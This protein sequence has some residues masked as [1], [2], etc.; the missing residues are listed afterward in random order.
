MHNSANYTTDSLNWAMHK[1]VGVVLLCFF[2]SSVRAQENKQQ[3]EEIIIEGKSKRLTQ[4][5]HFKIADIQRIQPQD[6]GQVLQ[7]AAG[8]TMRSYGGLGG[9]KTFSIRGLGGEHTKLVVNGLPYSNAQ[10]S[11]V[12]FSLF[13]PDNVCELSLEH[14]GKINDLRPAS[15]QVMGSSI[16]I[17]TFENSFADSAKTQVRKSFTLGSFGQ[18]ENYGAAK[19]NGNNSFIAAGFKLRYAH[20]QY[21]YRLRIGN[22]EY[23]GIRE[24]N[25]LNEKM[26]SLGMGKQWRDTIKNTLFEA[27]F[28]LQADDNQRELP[29]AIILYND[30][31]DETLH[32]QTIRTG[33]TI[34]QRAASYQ[35]KTFIVY[36]RNFLHYHDPSYFNSQGFIDNQYL[37]N[38]ISGGANFSK[39]FNQHHFDISHESEFNTLSSTRAELLNPTRY[40]ST[41][42][43]GYNYKSKYLLF[44]SKAF[45]QY[46]IDEHSIIA[47][48]SVHQRLNPFV[49]LKTTPGFSKI[50]EFSIWYRGS[51]R[52]ASFN[53]LYYSQIGNIDL[54][55]EESNQ[56]NFGTTFNKRVKKLNFGLSAN[57]YYNQ[58]TNKI[59]AIPTQNLFVWSIQNIGRAEIK[60]VALQGRLNFELSENTSIEWNGAFTYQDVLDVS[61]S[62]GPTYRH[63][64]AYTPRASANSS[65]SFF[66]KKSAVH[67]IWFYYGERY[68]LNQNVAQNLLPD[69]SLFDLN[70]SHRLQAR[71]KHEFE[72]A[73]GIRNLLDSQY[74]YIRNF[75]MPGR[76]YFISLKYAFN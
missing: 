30:L 5:T 14:A 1:I 18:I 70:I 38:G 41:T 33:A 39:K 11:L 34:E 13:Q 3:Y 23:P 57:L 55:P 72:L 75:V 56:L 37:N 50:F 7:F 29:G 2:I 60:G 44:T 15:A 45:H 73:A 28:F 59:L 68:S 71:N 4:N 22:I 66:Y 25:A 62:E 27:K 61:N 51:M 24:N 54:Q 8:T 20:G 32:T 6:L 16:S 19:Y 9:M 43:I 48:K 47:P 42:G 26:L 65:L 17:K 67:A 69:I 40:N 31:S 63:Q 35:W 52:P 21:P 12:D 64:L 53:E 49:Q 76:N 10:N 36:N 74:H 58:V 46:L